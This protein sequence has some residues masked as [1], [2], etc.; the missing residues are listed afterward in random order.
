MVGAT[1][2]E[3]AEVTRWEGTASLKVFALE[4]GGWAALALALVRLRDP[5]VGLL[6]LLGPEVSYF[7][8]RNGDLL[9]AWLVGI[10]TTAAASKIARL[11]WRAVGARTNRYR[12][13]NRHLVV[14]S[15]FFSK[16]IREVDLR[17]IDDVMVRR[18]FFGR[19]VG[20]GEIAVM[21]SEVDRKGPRTRVRL[22]GVVDPEAVH[23]LI[24]KAVHEAR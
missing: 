19:L 5:L 6:A 18:P 15:G 21:T 1:A 4:A 2:A 12:L 24:R 10:V 17:A 13:S 7:A 14:E 8:E 11:L 23:A 16:T 3:A 20:V 22:P 9:G